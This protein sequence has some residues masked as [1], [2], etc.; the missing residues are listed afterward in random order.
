MA[1]SYNGWPASADP[2]AININRNAVARGTTVR[3]PAGL[4]NGDVAFVL[5]YV[6]GEL[7]KRVERAGTG[8]WG[9]AYRQNRNARN[10]SCH[11]SGTAF[12]WNAPRHPN[13]KSGTFTSRQKATIH[14][15]LNEVEHAVKWGGD[16]TGTKDE[17]H[18]EICVGARDLAAIAKRLRARLAA[19]R[20]VPAWW[21][22]NLRRGMTNRSDIRI[23]RQKLHLPLDGSANDDDFDAELDGYVRR[24]QQRSGLE[25]DGVVG[26]L[27]AKVLG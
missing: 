22:T 19:Q 26:K 9:Y 13:G 12:D 7:H 8:V 14:A 6:A 1:T 11:A 20:P 17:M 16:F 18:F 21:T 23:V 5:G 3:F 10:L 24:F 25:P 2:A 15:I 4:K 27:T